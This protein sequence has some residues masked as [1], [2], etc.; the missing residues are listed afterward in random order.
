MLRSFTLTALAFQTLLATL[1]PRLGEGEQ[2]SVV[3]VSSFVAHRH[4]AT[5]PFGTTAAAKAALEA[6][7]RSAA[8]EYAPR[9]VRVNAVAPGFVEKDD[10]AKS[11]MSREAW[12]RA[13][14][15][16]PM[17]RLGRPDDVAQVIAFLL[18]PRVGYVTGQILRVDGGLTLG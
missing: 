1:A 8:A 13:V 12:E 2:A 7:V 17:G 5:T 3:A 10:P 9:G 15:Q 16:I 4:L 11:A 6:L 14:A 18:D